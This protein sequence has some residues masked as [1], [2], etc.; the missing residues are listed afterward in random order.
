[1]NETL[2]LLKNTEMFSEMRE[3]VLRSLSDVMRRIQV[4]PGTRIIKKGSKGKS[5][6]IIAEGTVKVHDGN[7]IHARLNAGDVF[8]E[9]ALLDEEKR[10][11][12]VTTDT[13]SVLYKLEQDELYELMSSNANF[14][15]GVLRAFDQA[16]AGAQ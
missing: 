11:A 8:G 13:A 1:M 14:L 7:H 6:F 5:M 9:Y 3:E 16:L 15:K 2:K 4:E 12:S 10:S